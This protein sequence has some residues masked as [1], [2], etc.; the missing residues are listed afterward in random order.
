MTY[1]VV[2]QDG[3][4]RISGNT[5]AHIEGLYTEGLECCL[6]IVFKG[7]NGRISLI[8]DT[9]RIDKKR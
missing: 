6:A 9:S 2:T 7:K 1:V 3:I 5:P 4:G 8:H